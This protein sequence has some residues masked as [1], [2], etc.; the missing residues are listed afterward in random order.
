MHVSRTAAS[1]FEPVL[2]DR[3]RQSSGKERSGSLGS[4]LDPSLLAKSLAASLGY[5]DV[6]MVS[7]EIQGHVDVSRHHMPRHVQSAG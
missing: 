6:Y 7:H 4:R 5:E 1:T 2:V 3:T